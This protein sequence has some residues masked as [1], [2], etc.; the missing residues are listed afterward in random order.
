[1]HVVLLTAGE[2]YKSCTYDYPYA[3]N[4]QHQ[5][6]VIEMTENPAYVANTGYSYI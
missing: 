3:F 2:E 1:M 6:G 5:E 4:A